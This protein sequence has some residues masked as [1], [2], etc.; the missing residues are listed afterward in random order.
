MM[1]NRKDD[2]ERMESQIGSLVSIMEADR[3]TNKSKMKQEIRVGQEH[4]KEIMETQF[5][6]LATK[7][8]GWRKETL[9]DREASKTM[10]L[11]ANPE[12]M[13]SE[14][15]HWEVPTEEAAVKSLGTMKKR[16]RSRHLAAG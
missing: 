15:E 16:H 6:S 3:K 4:I 5:A 8:D 13:K 14:M 11:K 10:D 1:A 9:A 2:Q 12:D 7:L